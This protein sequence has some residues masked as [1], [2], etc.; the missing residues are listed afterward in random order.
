MS[1]ADLPK[2]YELAEARLEENRGTR[3][4]IITI[5]VAAATAQMMIDAEKGAFAVNSDC[6]CSRSAEAET[7]NQKIFRLFR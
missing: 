1:N 5:K 4:K 6:V 7:Y 3:K 2:F